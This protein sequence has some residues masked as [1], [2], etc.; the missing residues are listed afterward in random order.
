[1]FQSNFQ[2]NVVA[3][4]KTKGFQRRQIVSNWEKYEIERED[5]VVADGGKDYGE[6]LSM[7][8]WFVSQY[9]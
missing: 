6:L 4:T 1:M 3:E 7:A 5:E 9:S 2:E 8:G